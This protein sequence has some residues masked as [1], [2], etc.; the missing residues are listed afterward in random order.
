M[1]GGQINIGRDL[2]SV[3]SV[4]GNLTIADGGHLDVT[5]N[6]RLG[7]QRTSGQHHERRFDLG[8]YGGLGER[9]NVDRQ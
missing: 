3:V 7:R 4:G 1:S 6:L 9:I 2:A 5:R 8:D